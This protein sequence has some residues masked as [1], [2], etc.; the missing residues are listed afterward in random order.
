LPF[1]D[2]PQRRALRFGHQRQ[3]QFPQPGIGIDEADIGEGFERLNGRKSRRSGAGA[4]VQHRPWTEYR[5][6]LAH[7]I[8]NRSNGR[9]G[10]RQAN[11]GVGENVVGRLDALRAAA[12]PVGP[13]LRR[14]PLGDCATR[15]TMGETP[16]RRLE[17]RRQIRREVLQWGLHIDD[18]F[19]PIVSLRA[20]CARLQRPCCERSML[21][22][23]SYS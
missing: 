12:G 6:R 15:H 8:E 13:R 11:E 5:Q 4:D 17:V 9:I 7:R 20:S 19:A 3:R 21:E 2:L 14:R 10:R 16:Q 1:A 23:P 18:F 22:C